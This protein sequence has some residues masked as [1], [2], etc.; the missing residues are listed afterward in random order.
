MR[1]Q[2]NKA[3]QSKKHK[4]KQKN[5]NKNPFDRFKS[6]QELQQRLTLAYSWFKL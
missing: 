3:K 2:K 6:K 4:N 5:K 1:K